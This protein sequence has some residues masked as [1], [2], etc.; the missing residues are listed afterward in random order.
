MIWLITSKSNETFFRKLPDSKTIFCIFIA[1]YS[2]C[3]ICKRVTKCIHERK[4]WHFCLTLYICNRTLLTTTI[5]TYN[6]F[7]LN[8]YICIQVPHLLYCIVHDLSSHAF[9][10]GIFNF[11]YHVRIW[12]IACLCSLNFF[13]AQTTVGESLEW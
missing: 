3:A 2:S 9:V 6:L 13:R 4:H 12:H 7:L 11:N 5:F 8:L 10:F 1:F